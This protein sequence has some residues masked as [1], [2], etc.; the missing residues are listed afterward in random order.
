MADGA[1]PRR[2]R[3]PRPR[4]RS[5]GA[6]PETEALDAGSRLN[7]AFLKDVLSDWE[8]HGA[9][10]IASA[11]AERPHDYLKLVT[12]LFSKDLNVRVNALDQLS[13]E[14]LSGQ[15][16]ALLAQLAG[17]GVD[18]CAGAGPAETAQPPQTLSTL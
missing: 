5:R 3:A 16:A 7:E 18:P 2:S 8:A 6:A 9:A 11:R 12:S 15:L 13:D 10:A 4:R 14:Q 1:N 17:A